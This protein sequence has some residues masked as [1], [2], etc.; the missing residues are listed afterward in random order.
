MQW[1]EAITMRSL[2]STKA[3]MALLLV[4]SA[5]TVLTHPVSAQQPPPKAVQPGGISLGNETVAPPDPSLVEK[6]ARLR[7]S[8]LQSPQA[9]D[10]LYELA[11]V[12]RQQKSLANPSKPT[13]A[14][15]NYRNPILSSFDP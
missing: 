9:A 15:R 2:Q 10:T 7:A 3:A 8:L 14:P 11:L 6:E 5:L 12:L 4:A 13:R 1:N